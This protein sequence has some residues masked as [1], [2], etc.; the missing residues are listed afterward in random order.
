MLAA[1][2]YLPFFLSLRKKEGMTPLRHILNYA[3]TG[4]VIMLARVTV[5]GMVYSAFGDE[6]RNVNLRPF[7]EFVAVYMLDEGM[8]LSQA[9]LNILMFVP[10]GM[11]LP[12]VFPRRAGRFYMTALI[13]LGTTVLI[14]A[15]QYFIGRASDIDDVIANL[16][17]GIAGYALYLLLAAA[18]NGSGWFK[19]LLPEY[20][21]PSWRP[22]AAA[23]LFIAVVFLLPAGLDIANQNSEFGMLRQ[24]TQTIPRDAVI[25]I[26]PTEDEG[27]APVYANEAADPQ[28]IVEG[29]VR[30]YFPD[31]EL[32]YSTNMNDYYG[33]CVYA[34]AM[35]GDI[36]LR[37]FERDGSYSMSFPDAGGA[38]DMTDAE[39]I[40]YAKGYA[41]E[42]LREGE[43]I[44]DAEIL[45]Y[46]DGQRGVAITVEAESADAYV[47]GSFLVTT[48]AG[49]I[50]VHNQL[51]RARRTGDAATISEA[52]AL[53]A[54]RGVAANN[55][56]C[57][58]IVIDSLEL[59]TIE[60]KHRW[61]PAYAFSGTAV[62]D[63]K[64]IEWVSI[65]D[66]VK[67]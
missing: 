6:V 39:L 62:F 64:S 25:N 45:D 22:L 65:V 26:L 3:F 15:A 9:M 28:A 51:T 34:N 31:E 63:G 50:N 35:A 33:L 53:S 13:V 36:F 1:V 17:G 8:Y 54:A 21:R 41:L 32:E 47:T 40:E 23:G 30:K 24:V 48:E 10:L 52:E 43:I 44:K 14:E 7:S 61:I 16:V 29:L 4:Y 5:T 38:S 67:R 42:S 60:R 66:A 18:L 58:D 19:R 46:G 59:V 57:T 2:I 20:S 55:Y 12:L 11:L 27:S 56:P 37:A 49:E